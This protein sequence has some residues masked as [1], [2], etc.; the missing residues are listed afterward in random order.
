MTATPVTSETAETEDI[1]S[2]PQKTGPFEASFPSFYFSKDEGICKRFTYGGC[3]G[4]GNRFLSE[5]ACKKRCVDTVQ[6]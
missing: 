4:N 2:L 1:C 5:K 3:E 6:A